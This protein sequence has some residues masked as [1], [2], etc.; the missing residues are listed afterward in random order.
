MNPIKRVSKD[1]ENLYKNLKENFNLKMTFTEFTKYLSDFV[2]FN[3]DAEELAK[4]IKKI[5]KKRKSYL[6]Y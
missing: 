3:F 6:L 1:L 2:L 5:K 4:E